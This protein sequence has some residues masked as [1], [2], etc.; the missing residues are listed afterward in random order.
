M[1][2]LNEASGKFVY[3][4]NLLILQLYNDMIFSPSLLKKY[5][6]KTIFLIFI[7][8]FIDRSFHF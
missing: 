8:I 5:G 1:K 2:Y 4:H 6:S 3:N 7:H